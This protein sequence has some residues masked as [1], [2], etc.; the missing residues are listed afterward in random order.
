MRKIEKIN[1][2]GDS[3][4][5]G[6]NPNGDGVIKRNYV[7]ILKELLNLKLVSNYCI[8][9][10]SFTSYGNA[11]S[12]IE[13]RYMLMDKDADLVIVFA[14]VNDYSY[15]EA[16]IY[17]IK[18]SLN[19]IC[20]GLKEIYGDKVL[21]ITPSKEALLEYN[22]P[23]SFPEKNKNG[24]SLINVVEEIKMVATMY[25]FLVYDL[26]NNQDE[27]KDKIDFEKYMP[28]G[29]HPTEEYHE[30][31]AKKIYMFMKENL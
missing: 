30:I 29:I 22:L 25:R 3:I 17:D 23:F 18:V 8:P 19:K 16:G 7:R 4:T 27:I 24:V 6:Q 12:P 1:F 26:Y 15:N 2:L 5:W 21:F 20:R 9:G 14:G 31:L 13:K 28:D 10:S 11:I